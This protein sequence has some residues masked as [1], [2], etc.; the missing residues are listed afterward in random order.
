MLEV[1]D[2]EHEYGEGASVASRLADLDLEVLSEK[3][4][5]VEAGQ[6]VA[7]GTMGHLFEGTILRQGGRKEILQGAENLAFE[8]RPSVELSQGDHP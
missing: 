4:H 5:V 8:P 3:G 1:I 2:I 6:A 7:I